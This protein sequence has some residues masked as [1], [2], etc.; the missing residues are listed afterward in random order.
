MRRLLGM[1][2]FGASLAMPVQAQEAPSPEALQAA[3]KLAAVI[4]VDT[5]QQMTAAIFQQMWSGLEGQMAD[6][7][8]TA[9]LADLRSELERL[10]VKFAADAM[11]DA[12]AIYARHFTAAEMNDML[13]FDR[14]PTGAK[15][16]REMPK[17]A[18]ESAALM[19]P[20]MASFQQEISAKME[21]IM[22]KHGYK[23]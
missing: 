16:L 12:P 13:A 4:S 19:A 6:K 3:Q 21:E 18:G 10:V 20:R 1:I 9:T 5:M 8:D 23:P 7:N 2:L 14:T 22:K 17:V 11:K 15:A